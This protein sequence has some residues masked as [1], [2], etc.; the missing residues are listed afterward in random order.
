ML[1]IRDVARRVLWDTLSLMVDVDCPCGAPPP[2]PCPACRALLASG[3][4]RVEARHPALEM[5][6]G[7]DLDAPLGPVEL[8]VPL[9]PLVA[10]TDY[11]DRTRALVLAWKNG[12][13]AALVDPLS[14]ALRP[15]WDRLL[16]E[17]GRAGAV[18]PVIIPLPST[19]RARLRRGEDHTAELARHLARRTGARVQRPL[20]LHDRGQKGQGVRGR[21]VR[22]LGMRPGWRPPASGVVLLDDVATTGASLRAAHRAV[23][24]AGGVVHGALVLA[25][26]PGPSPGISRSGRGKMEIPRSPDRTVPSTSRR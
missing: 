12:G 3:P 1:L 11:D 15:A 21:S 8:S 13:R 18:S 20:R 16:A 14:A 22:R 23:V 19:L 10:A 2:A 4:R 25:S 24:E 17:T 26:A 9:M 7:A 6:T 5:V